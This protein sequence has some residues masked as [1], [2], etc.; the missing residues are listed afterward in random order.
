MQRLV[1]SVILILIASSALAADP[2]FPE[3]S[4][5]YFFEN[6]K[7]LREQAKKERQQYLLPKGERFT[8]NNAAKDG[9]VA[10]RWFAVAGDPESQA[11]M[12]DLFA[13]GLYEPHNLQSAVYWYKL[14]AENGNIYAQYMMGLSH[15]RGWLGK[16]DAQRANEYFLRAN[17]NDD[18]ARARR[19]VAQFFADRDNA[20][21]N[22]DQSYQWFETAAEEGDI[23]S[24]LTLGDFFND[25]GRS[26][27][28]T[29]SALRWYGRAAAKQDPY[30]QYSLGIIYL[31]GD[32]VVPADLN[33]AVLWIEKSAHQQ[34]AAAQAMLGR[35]YYTG[36][37][38][39]QNNA[40][41]YAWWT[42]A[43]RDPNPTLYADIAQVTKKMSID[44][45]EQAVKLADYYAVMFAKGGMVAPEPQVTQARIKGAKYK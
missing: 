45:L 11:A 20:M 35:L 22:Y 16:V 3:D 28:N 4:F 9:I 25:G 23:Q 19:Q 15:Q 12:G 2:P 39:P 36:K 8:D 14:A 32:K 34:F 37:G 38:V 6:Q 5:D 1:C 17:A 41:A 18:S 31:Q 27:K 26:G 29:L 33:Q 21:Y 10:L 44:E 13:K 40:L 30:A 42:M 24:Q 43:N 7:V